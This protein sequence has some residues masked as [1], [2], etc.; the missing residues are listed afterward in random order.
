MT[1]EVEAFS[2]NDTNLPAFHRQGTQLD[3]VRPGGRLVSR[4]A[5]DAYRQLPSVTEKLW[6]VGEF[7]VNEQA[8]RQIMAWLNQ[9]RA[10]G[11]EITLEGFARAQ[12]WDRA[13]IINF[14]V[15]QFSE[16]EGIDISADTLAMARIKHAAETAQVEL[17]RR[18][19]TEV[20]LPFITVRQGNGAATTLSLKENIRHEDYNKIK[21]IGNN[22][23]IEPWI[24]N[25]SIFSVRCFSIRNL[26]LS[27]APN[28]R[29]LYCY[30]NSLSYLD[31]SNVPYLN[32]LEC[33][34]NK[35]TNI[36]LSNV[37]Q[38]TKLICWKNLLSEINL[39]KVP[40]LNS[41]K[42]AN[43]STGSRMKELD[44]SD[45]LTTEFELDPITSFSRIIKRSDQI[46]SYRV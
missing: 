16:K 11:E 30:G 5:G 7:E 45:C 31:I 33:Q 9:I 2:K 21:N 46:V 4:I 38:L 25:N 23:N 35:L 41:L 8:Y 14:L 3:G 6:P 18:T 29:K 34:E 43:Q 44:I 12:L 15:E 36:D 24:K 27:N 40:K 17:S 37:P 42:C 1:N 28:L 10:T 13:I 20:S 39:S 32:E 22:K 19:S 26:D